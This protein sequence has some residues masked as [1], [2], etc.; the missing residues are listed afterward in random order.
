MPRVLCSPPNCYLS[1]PR[2]RPG[3]RTLPPRCIRPNPWSMFLI[4]V[5]GQGYDRKKVSYMYSRWKVRFYRENP[6]LDERAIKAKMNEELCRDIAASNRRATSRKSSADLK[7]TRARRR[8]TARANT[9]ARKA[10][11]AKAKASAAKA[12]AAK[13]SAAKAKASKISAAKGS[14]AKASGTSAKAST[15]F[16]ADKPVPRNWNLYSKVKSM[17]RFDFILGSGRS[18]ASFLMDENALDRM[19]PGRWFNDELIGAYMALLQHSS[20][21]QDNI[22]LHGLF[23]SMYTVT[24]QLLPSQVHDPKYSN[25]PASVRYALVKS[26]TRRLNTTG[27]VKIFVPVNHG[28]THWTLIVIDVEKKHVLSLDSFNKERRV[29]RKEMLDWIEQEHLSKKKPFDKKEWTTHKVKVPSQTNGVDCGVFTCMFAA[30]LAF[31][32]PLTFKQKDMAK[33][34]A[35][36]AWSILNKTL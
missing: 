6:G 15:P 12:S 23:Y 26:T 9:E 20:A 10:A 21:G 17:T 27:P 4:R 8:K 29:Q 11:A 18:R 33:M 35:R 7:Q 25:K 2:K 24:G 5:S 3:R 14:K 1:R 13:A 28:N 34:R 22:F 31:D 30:Y 36:L 32:R 19:L 16:F